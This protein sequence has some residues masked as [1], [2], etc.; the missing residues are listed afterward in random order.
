[1]T[2][3]NSRDISYGGLSDESASTEFANFV[4]NGNGAFS[5]PE[6]HPLIVCLNSIGY[7]I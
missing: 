4:L 6:N 7:L 3:R 2:Y 1:M 5:T